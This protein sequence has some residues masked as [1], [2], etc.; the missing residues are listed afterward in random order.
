[1]HQLKNHY[2]LLPSPFTEEFPDLEDKEAPDDTGPSKARL[3]RQQC[4][5]GYPASS[6]CVHVCMYMCARMWV[7]M[8][9]ASVTVLNAYLYNGVCMHL[10]VYRLVCGPP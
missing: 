10:C 2:I 9:S 7:S 8:L 6:V 4:M 5:G 1:M 3:P